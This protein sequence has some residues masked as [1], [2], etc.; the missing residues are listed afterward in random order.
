MM[1]KTPNAND[2]DPQV[3]RIKRIILVRHGYSMG[4]HDGNNY[5]KYGDCNVPLHD[6]GWEQAIACGMF[7]KDYYNQKAAH[8][9]GG[10]RIWASS[11]RRTLETT[12]GIVY[13]AQGALD[14]CSPIFE[15][16]N[17]VEQDF[18]MFAHY[19]DRQWQEKN[20]SLERAFVDARRKQS[21]FFSRL[22][23]GES[24]FDTYIRMGDVI[25][26]MQRDAQRKGVDDLIVVCHGVTL[27]AFATRFLHISDRAWDAFRNPGNCDVYAIELNENDEYG[28][29][30]I[31]DGQKGQKVNEDILAEL[32]K[33]VPILTPK[34]L[35]SV[36]QHI[37]NQFK[38]NR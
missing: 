7:L 38:F 35:P 14:H 26:S 36:P 29:N 27:R 21:K 6:D 1:S 5:Q 25:A 16:A 31:Y 22:P 19:A 3:K 11:F 4:N 8:F 10:P 18:G 34:T 23:H 20:M 24:P 28:L 37:K 32:R 33:E 15:S 30:R 17:L 13:G 12:S 9:E 2:N